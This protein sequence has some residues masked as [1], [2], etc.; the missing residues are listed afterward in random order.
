MERGS[1]KTYLGIDN[2]VSGAVT[3]L[4]DT[5]DIIIH[6]NTPVKN[7]LNYTKKKAFINRVDFQKMRSILNLAG[8]NTFCLIERPMVNPMRWNASVSA[9]R[10]LEA[11]Q[12]LLENFQI[13]YQ[14]ID[15]KE[16]QKALLPSG[17]VKDQ[18]KTGADQVAK[19]LYPKATIVNSDALLIAHYCRK[20]YK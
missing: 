15:S 8:D 20:M 16:W 5:G 6:I 10:C 4:S 17:L 3:I 12:I 1:S 7:C 9:L 14:F 13:P 2:G 11:T 18:L 19:R